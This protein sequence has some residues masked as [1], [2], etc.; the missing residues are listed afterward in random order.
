MRK[1]LF[2]LIELL[3]VIAI[4]AI[5][6][7]LL[8]PALNRARSRARDLTCSSNLKQIGTM[9]SMYVEQNGDI[10]PAVSRNFPTS[11]NLYAG[12]WQDVLAATFLA[13]VPFSG[14][15][16]YYD[17]CALK[18]VGEGGLCLPR[19][20]LACPSSEPFSP[21]KSR[22]HYG[23][24]KGSEGKRAGFASAVGGPDMKVT[25]IKRPSER[26]A[27][28]DIAIWLPYSPEPGA[29][30]KSGMVTSTAAGAGIWRHGGNSGANVCFAD[31]HVTFVR[32][33]N[34]PLNY[35][36]NSSLGYFWSTSAG[37]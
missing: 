1:R 34:I 7:S 16:R 31:G 24:N 11:A 23:I 18:V 26:A 10:V 25:R 32:E 30:E 21:T 9:M 3:V 14:N 35:Y 33:R 36:Y 17:N 2:T 4:I 15:T 20:V 27:M 22:I 12:K 6:A 29:I 19:G 8:L 28:F 5:L 37:I 13:D